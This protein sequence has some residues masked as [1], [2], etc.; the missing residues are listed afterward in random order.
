VSKRER[1][2]EKERERECVC[3]CKRNRAEVVEE[4]E[5]VEESKSLCNRH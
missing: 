3:V 1:E 4:V 5:K 2:R